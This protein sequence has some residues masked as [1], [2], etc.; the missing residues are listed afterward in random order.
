M[1]HALGGDIGQA[2]VEVIDRSV[3]DPRLQ[4]EGE[5]RRLSLSEVETGVVDVD[6]E[7]DGQVGQRLECL[8]GRDD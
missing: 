2:E 3:N 8:G 6:T 4:T 7:A 5:P 1:G